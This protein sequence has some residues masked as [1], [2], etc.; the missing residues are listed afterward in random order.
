MSIG[1][2]KIPKCS[3]WY[4]ELMVMM[5]ADEHATFFWHVT[6]LVSII[7]SLDKPKEG[8]YQGKALLLLNE[9]GGKWCWKAMSGLQQI[10]KWRGKWLKGCLR[11]TVGSHM[12]PSA[13]MLSIVSFA[14][15]RKHHMGSVQYYSWRNSALV[16]G[17]DGL[18]WKCEQTRLWWRVF[19][20]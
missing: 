20:L 15:N 18:S 6:V 4:F 16:K 17:L 5:P 10:T 12:M 19:L 3:W 2:D 1:L 11:I 14:L 7:L 8:T 9:T 13:L